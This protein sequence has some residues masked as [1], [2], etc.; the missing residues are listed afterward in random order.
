M[1]TRAITRR[2]FVVPLANND[3]GKTTMIR[4]L[5]RQGARHGIDVVKRAVRTLYSP[6]G[7]VIDALVIPRSY[8]E[9]LEEEFG[10]VEGALDGVDPH[11]RQRD[12]I[13]FPSHLKAAD[14]KTMMKLARGAGFDVIAVPVVLKPEELPKYADCL[15]LG[16]NERWTVSNDHVDENPGAQIEALGHDLWAWIAA[17]LEHR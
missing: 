16:W 17:A 9:T 2:L 6:W 4:S 3:H 1:L 11:W 7:R 5:V 14:C 15:E 10:S 8:Q 13:V 12:L